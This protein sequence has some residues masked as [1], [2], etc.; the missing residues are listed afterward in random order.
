MDGTYKELANILGISD[1]EVNL[2]TSERIF[3]V[4]ISDVY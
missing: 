1:D 3:D 2:K 4:F